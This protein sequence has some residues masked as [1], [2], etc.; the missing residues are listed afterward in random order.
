MKNLNIMGI[1]SKVICEAE[2]PIPWGDFSDKEN[3]IF[4]KVKWDEIDFYT[5]SFSFHH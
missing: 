1:L 4:S 5:S 3:K 2:L